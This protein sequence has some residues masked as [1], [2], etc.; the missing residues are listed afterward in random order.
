MYANKKLNMFA[1]SVL[2]L[3]L[4]ARKKQLAVLY[5]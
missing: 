4:L 1:F 3:H 5:P 2:D